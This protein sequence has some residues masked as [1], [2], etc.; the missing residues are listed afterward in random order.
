MS[1][2][3]ALPFQQSRMPVLAFSLG[4]TQRGDLCVA[5]CQGRKLSQCTSVQCQVL[6][7][8]SNFPL[9]AA[10][11]QEGKIRQAGEEVANGSNLC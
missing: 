11:C 8:H 4:V 3:S 9:K 6:P 2:L 5:G 1:A 10:A 7:G